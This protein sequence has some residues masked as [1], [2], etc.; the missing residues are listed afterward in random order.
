[1]TRVSKGGSTGMKT[2]RLDKT[3]PSY[4]IGATRYTPWLMIAP[5]W[6]EAEGVKLFFAK[7]LGVTGLVLI[8]TIHFVRVLRRESCFADVFVLCIMLSPWSNLVTGL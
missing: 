6:C 8:S 3:L 1:M 5:R 7:N 2:R 4:H